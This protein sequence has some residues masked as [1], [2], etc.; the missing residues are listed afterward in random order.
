MEQKDTWDGSTFVKSTVAKE[1]VS[2]EQSLGAWGRAG[3]RQ[4]ERASKS[5]L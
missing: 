4:Q 2:E 5:M 1:L 3:N